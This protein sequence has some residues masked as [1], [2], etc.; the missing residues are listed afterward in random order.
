MSNFRFSNLF[1]IFYFILFS[2][3]TCSSVVKRKRKLGVGVENVPALHS[4][5]LR[6]WASVSSFFFKGLDWMVLEALP[7]LIFCNSNKIC[8]FHGFLF[9]FCPQNQIYNTGISRFLKMSFF[10]LNHKSQR[11][12]FKMRI[13]YRLQ[14]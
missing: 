11:W 3:S 14:Q 9:F 5:A 7:A 1:A 6:L 12:D 4:L 8:Y 2:I 10:P 13:S